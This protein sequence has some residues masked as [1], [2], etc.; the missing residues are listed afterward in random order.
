VSALVV[1]RVVAWLLGAT[2]LPLLVVSSYLYY[3]RIHNVGASSH[4]DELA[5]FAAVAV[6][7]VCV[8]FLARQLAWFNR[9]LWPNALLVVLYVVVA[10]A[11]LFF[12]SLGFVCAEFGACL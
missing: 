7:A 8:H 5:L 12:Y 2:V 6:G 9:R 1:T 4:G 3:S 10:T 11:L